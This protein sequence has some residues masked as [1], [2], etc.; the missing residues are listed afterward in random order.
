MG[1]Q[2]NCLHGAVLLSTQNTCFFF[3]LSFFLSFFQYFL[4]SIEDL[5]WVF[6][7]PSAK[8]GGDLGG[9]GGG[10]GGVAEIKDK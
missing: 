6:R 1:T 9:G 5:R 3:F 7:I 4:T 10:G 8:R 2:K